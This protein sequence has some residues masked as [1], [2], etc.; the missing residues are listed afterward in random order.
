MLKI[1]YIYITLSKLV[2]LILSYFIIKLELGVDIIHDYL[3][4][5]FIEK[6]LST[7][8]KTYLYYSSSFDL[9][10]GQN[11]TVGYTWVDLN[12]ISYNLAAI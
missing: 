7:Y 8:F 3:W 1:I 2:L 10:S 5:F 6:K 9:T 11:H 4:N 12:P